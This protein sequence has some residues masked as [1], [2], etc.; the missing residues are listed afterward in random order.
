MCK[1]VQKWELDSFENLCQKYG[2]GGQDFYRYLQLCDYFYRKVNGS[3][4][5]EL[6]IVI[7]TFIDA[8]NSGSN[9]GLVSKLYHG[10]TSL[11][12][13][14]TDYVKQRWEKELDVEITEDMWLNAWETQSSSTN[15]RTWRDF[16]WK[17]LIRFFITPKQKSKQTGTQL[18]CWRECGEIMVD[19]A[20]VFWS[21]PS[22]Q[23]FW[24]EVATIISKT[25]G[26]TISTTFTSL[27][28]GHIPDGLSKDDA[29]L[30]KILLAASK[31]AITRHWLQKN[32]PTAS[33]F[34]K[35]VKHLHLL[36]QMTYSIRPQKELGEKRWEKWRAYLANETH[37]S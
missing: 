8:Y 15:S 33:L 28:L 4:S 19:H 21:C 35:I 24:K 14:T 26:F 2:L 11:N 16:C 3:N 10:I 30:L 29:Y 37:L 5:G 36:E 23:I 20:H 32:C 7:H 1:I 27:Y 9:K 6:P 25:L 13:D 22:I 18:F 12:K 31:K 17:N 34:I